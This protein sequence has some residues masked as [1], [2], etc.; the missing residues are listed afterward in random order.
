MGKSGVGI[1]II[2]GES[3]RYFSIKSYVMDAYYNRL[4]NFVKQTYLF[5]HKA[6]FPTLNDDS[7]DF[8]SF[9]FVHALAS[10]EFIITSLL[11]V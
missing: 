2:K 11:I 7:S 4:A 3:I 1:K 10:V 5:L 9:C 6:L 8:S